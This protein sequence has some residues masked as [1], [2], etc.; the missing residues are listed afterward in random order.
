MLLVLSGVGGGL[1]TPWAV[2]ELKVTLYG[3]YVEC[4]RS[5]RR[6]GARTGHAQWPARM[7]HNKLRARIVN[8]IVLGINTCR[9]GPNRRLT[10][11][12][13]VCA[14]PHVTPS[15]AQT[16]SATPGPPHMGAQPPGQVHNPFL[17]SHRAPYFSRILHTQTRPSR[18]LLATLMGRK[19]R[20]ACVLRCCTKTYAPARPRVVARHPSLR[21]PPS[22]PPSHPSPLPPQTA[23]PY[24]TV[25]TLLAGSDAP[26]RSPDVVLVHTK[27]ALRPT[28]PCLSPVCPY[29]CAHGML[30]APLL[31]GRPQPS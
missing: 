31:A 26:M 15:C 9:L 27:R 30:W 28:L 22:L 3:V 7:T 25:H 18:A 20:R 6:L 17:P 19:A 21:C 8:M 16:A 29:M 10:A 13:A 11:N 12:V 2:V 5:R 24:T 1:C 23:S 4:G 14:H